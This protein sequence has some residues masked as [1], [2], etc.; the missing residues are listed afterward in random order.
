M[1]AVYLLEQEQA[2]LAA[3]AEALQL[4]VVLQ[5]LGK[6]ALEAMERHLASQDHL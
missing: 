2:N 6:A 5:H 3:V 4:L 1:M